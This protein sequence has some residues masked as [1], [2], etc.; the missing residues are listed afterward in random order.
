MLPLVVMALLTA[1]GEVKTKQVSA[2]SGNPVVDGKLKEYAGAT[3]VKP[4]GNLP[5][6]P[7]FVGKLGFK[8]DTLFLA[9]ELT[10]LSRAADEQLQVS[11]FFP[12]A[13]TTAR[14]HLHTFGVEGRLPANGPDAWA[15]GQLKTATER[16]ARG[17]NVEVGIPA[18]AL[19]RFPATEPLVLELCLTVGKVSSCHGM[20]PL[21]P[22][23]VADDF[24]KGLKLQPPENV[25]ALEHVPA[26]W[27][28]FGELH[29]PY[30]IQANKPVTV[31]LLSTLFE[32][33]VADPAAVGVNLPKTLTVEGQPLLGVV[34]GE[35]PY[36][37]K[38]KCNADVEL[39]VAFYKVDGQVARRVMDWPVSTCQL[40]RA[41]SVS[42]EVDTL[43][44]GYSNGPVTTFTWVVDHFERTELGAR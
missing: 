13:G 17:Y 19:P 33:T 1:P 23:R 38:G 9:V 21:E 28:G 5:G 36:A 3:T 6:D 30:W 8:K 16:T 32:R 2:L 31:E 43:T 37:V 26:G 29:R 7:N 18:T 44:M 14:G 20:T 4:I 39:R 22:L 24:R 11:L 12:N 34:T 10:N 15:D 25:T 41:V 27:V 42:M 40:G 35:D